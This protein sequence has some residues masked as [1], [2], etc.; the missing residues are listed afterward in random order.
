LALR[1]QN[2]SASE[3]KRLETAGILRSLRPPKLVEGSVPNEVPSTLVPDLQPQL[4]AINQMV[5][6][7]QETTAQAAA[8]ST[9]QIDTMNVAL[10]RISAA[11]EELA[12]QR[13]WKKLRVL[14]DRDRNDYIREATIERVEG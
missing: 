3:R 6:V 13:N 11:M 9:S 4:D 7:V 14:V 1:V 12:E 2:L 5:A 8:M 10:A